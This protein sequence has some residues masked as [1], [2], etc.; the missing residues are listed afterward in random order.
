MASRMGL[1]GIAV[2]NCFNLKTRSDCRSNRTNAVFHGVAIEFGRCL[3]Q[4]GRIGVTDETF[5]HELTKSP[6][7][8]IQCVIA[9]SG[10][11]DKNVNGLSNSALI[12]AGPWNETQYFS[13]KP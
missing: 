5:G 8:P 13:I 7:S 1:G 11:P 9:A 2:S 6:R 12:P 10:F 4:S 3:Q